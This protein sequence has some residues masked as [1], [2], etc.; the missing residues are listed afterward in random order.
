MSHSRDRL[1][2]EQNAAYLESVR[3]D[4]EKVCSNRYGV[5]HI[6]R[7]FK[8]AQRAREDNERRQLDEQQQKRSQVG[9]SVARERSDSDMNVVP[10]ILPTSVNGSSR[11]FLLNLLRPST[12]LSKSPYACRSTSL[13]VDAFDVTSQR[14]TCSNS[15][16]RILMCPISSNCS[17][18]IHVNATS[19]STSMVKPSAS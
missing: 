17:G 11:P 14:N 2:E 7:P 15:P 3:A 10:R 4:E 13:C 12:T 8:A 9:R 18:V 6:S 19:T 1:L 16:G 5:K